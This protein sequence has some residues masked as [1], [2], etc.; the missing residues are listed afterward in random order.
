VRVLNPFDVPDDEKARR[1]AERRTERVREREG[2]FA[3]FVEPLTAEQI[4]EAARKHRAKFQATMD[5]LQARGEEFKAQVA[6]IVSSTE[7]AALEVRRAKLPA[8]PEF[9]ADYW[10]RMWEVVSNESRV[11]L[12]FESVEHTA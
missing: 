11:N 5:R 7:L 2:L 3:K 12:E 9:H 4:Q 10:R 1:I 6:A 8:G